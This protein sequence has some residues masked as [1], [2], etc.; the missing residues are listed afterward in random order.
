MPA[1]SD[2]LSFARGQLLQ[3]PSLPQTSFAGK[4]IVITGANTGLGFECAKQVA[5]LGASTIILGCRNITK[6]E[7][8]K[9]NIPH[10]EKTT[11]HVWQ[12]DMAD[13]SS[14]KAFAERLSTLP[15]LDAV[16]ANAGISTN[17][18]SVAESF[19]STLTVNVISTFLLAL[20]V[21][22]QLRSQAQ[23][24]HLTI[25][26]SN[27]HCFADHTQ[28]QHPPQ[29]E[30]FTTLSDKQ[31]A[32]MAARYFLSK[33]MVML[34]VQELASRTDSNK[35]VVNCPSPGW[36]KTELFR[37]DDG[38]FMG[39]N[40]LKLIGRTPE[41]GARCLTSAITAGKDTHGQYLSECR[42]K[43]ASVFVRSSEGQQLQRTL[44]KE[45]L[46]VIERIAPGAT[47]V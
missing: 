20:L 31:Q 22:P 14:V 13:F 33:L 12:I 5:A 37:Q 47:K 21:L 2:I 15:R 42:V 27:V 44:F 9:K 41:E 4:T 38:G 34:C 19:E 24:T 32:D 46:Q 36:C 26:G 29:G 30:V 28:L 18:Y 1:P 7:A 16:L 39:R 43:P 10:D 35:V 40:M 6:G 11:I 25:V 3:S 17:Q 8:A 23:Q 45:L